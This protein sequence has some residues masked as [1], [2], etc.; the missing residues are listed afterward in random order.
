[1]ERNLKNLRGLSEEAKSAARNFF[2]RPDISYTMLGLND[3]I[4]VWNDSGKKKL[5]K[6]YLTMFLREA[7]EVY[8]KTQDYPVSFST[9]CNLRLK[10]VLLLADSPKDQCRCLIHENLFLKLNAMGISYDSSFWTKVLY[11]TDD[12]S[13]CWNSKCDDCKNGK[14]L[15]PMKLINAMTT[16]RQSEK[17]TVEK[18]CDQDEDESMDS[19][20]RKYGTKLQCQSKQVYVGEVVKLFEASFQ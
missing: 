4:T 5:R 7:H 14:K 19:I 17:V 16:L 11:S 12:N 18:E 13:N 8:H 10:N 3:V 20:N 6:Y 2:F 9:F 15:F 1:M